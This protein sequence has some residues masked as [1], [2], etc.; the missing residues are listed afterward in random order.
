VHENFIG[1][2][3]CCVPDEGFTLPGGELVGSALSGTQWKATGNN[4]T[5]NLDAGYLVIDGANNNLL[6]AN[7]AS[8]NGTYDIDLTADTYRFGFLTP[9]SFENRVIA[10]PFANI[11]IKDC[12]NDNIISGGIV[13]PNDAAHPCN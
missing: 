11:R 8:N 10:A 13:E 12:G 7:N 9:A 5:G 1:I 3:L 2:I 6:V 4:A